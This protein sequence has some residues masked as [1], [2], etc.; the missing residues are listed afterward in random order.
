MVEIAC[1]LQGENHST[2]HA[3][4]ELIDRVTEKIDSHHWTT[5][6]FLDLSKAFDT[7][8]HNILLDKLKFYGIQ[9]NELN[10]MKSYL[11]NRQQCTLY[12]D[13]LSDLQK[14]THGIPQG[15]NLGPLLFI[16]YI[17]DITNLSPLISYILFADDTN[18]LLSDYD[19]NQLMHMVNGE[20]EKVDDWLKANKL[21]LN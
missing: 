4:V 14:I 21:S 11:Q 9:S 1:W 6:I 17:N 19:E 10:L 3:I 20:L 5:G 12:N 7:L 8:N 18:L 13:I 15:S 16:I 2:D